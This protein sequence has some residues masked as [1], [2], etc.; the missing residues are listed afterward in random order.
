MKVLSIVVAFTLCV[1]V[2]GWLAMLQPIVMSI[3]AAFLALSSDFD[4]VTDLQPITWKKWL[5]AK[6]EN[7]VSEQE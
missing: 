7:K 4:L 5:S 1:A 3:G 2:K 6:E